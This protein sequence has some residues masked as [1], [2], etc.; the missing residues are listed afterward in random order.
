MDAAKVTIIFSGLFVERY[1]ES[2]IYV[3]GSG[4]IKEAITYIDSEIQAR[5]GSRIPYVLL[6]NDINYTAIKK[7]KDILLKDKD[8]LTVIPIVSGG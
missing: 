8:I 3:C 7:N 4:N 6:I 1:R 2:Q 5:K